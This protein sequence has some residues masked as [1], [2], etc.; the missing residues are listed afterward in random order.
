MT[1][2][3][4]KFCAALYKSWYHIE[5]TNQDQNNGCPYGRELQGTSVQQMNCKYYTCTSCLALFKINSCQDTC[6]CIII[7]V[8]IAWLA[9]KQEIAFTTDYCSDFLH[10][11]TSVLQQHIAKLLATSMVKLHSPLPLDCT[12][13]EHA[14]KIL[15]SLE[16]QM[17]TW[18]ACLCANNMVSSLWIINYA[19]GSSFVISGYPH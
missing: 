12:A 8:W 6:T 15:S 7:V 5:Y 4:S 3:R 17:L 14:D 19:N 9:I 18:T 13:S 16:L 2:M 10:L 1:Y 11:P